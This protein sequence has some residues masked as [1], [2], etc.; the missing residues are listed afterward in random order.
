MRISDWSSDVCS[1]DLPGGDDPLRHGLRQGVPRRT[2]DARGADLPHRP[3]EPA[4]HSELHRREGDR[5]RV[6]SGTRVS[7]R[8]DLG[9]RRILKKKNQITIHRLTT[10]VTIITPQIHHNLLSHTN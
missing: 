2:A 3:G 10:S 5:K 6:A 8:V 9:G 1:S 7:V 4:T